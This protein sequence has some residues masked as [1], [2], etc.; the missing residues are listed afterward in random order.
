MQEE[1][2]EQPQRTVQIGVGC[3]LEAFPSQFDKGPPSREEPWIWY[4]RRRAR[5]ALRRIVR[6]IS[7][8][9][10]RPAV[11]VAAQTPAVAPA[12]VTVPELKP[13][14][15]VRVRSAEVIRSTLD[16]TGKHR[17]CGFGLGMYQYCGKELR[18]AKVVNQF[19]DEARWRMLKAR[20]MVLLEGVHCDGSS[21]SD[22]RGCDRMC[23]YFWRTEWLEKIEEAPGQR[24]A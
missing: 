1:Q 20:N 15:L 8:I 9:T 23:F 6:L 18:V 7:H 11:P 17:G 12:P 2:S 3:Q 5:G 10:G 16:E 4:F 22:T 13:G 19:F 24:K 14:D 21:I